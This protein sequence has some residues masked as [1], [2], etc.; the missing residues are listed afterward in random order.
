MTF[1]G[2]KSTVFVPGNWVDKT[3]HFGFLRK[4]Y[5]MA[6]VGVNGSSL[7]PKSRL[8]VFCKSIL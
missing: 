6:K 3:D 1:S 4:I 5:I 2:P 7:G 8:A